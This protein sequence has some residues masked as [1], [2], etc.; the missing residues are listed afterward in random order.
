MLGEKIKAERLRRGLSQQELADML[1]VVRQTVSKWEKGL[2]VPDSEMLVR[3]AEVLGTSV[4]ELLDEDGE[5][6]E[7]NA[8][9]GGKM[10]FL[11]KDHG[12][13][14]RWDQYAQLHKRCRQRDAVHLH[15]PL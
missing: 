4:S 15:I 14:Q 10:H 12:G 6:R 9:E 11:L 8:E 2:S 7:E 5:K 13:Q 1:S 3:I